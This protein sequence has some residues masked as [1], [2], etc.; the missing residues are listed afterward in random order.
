MGYQNAIVRFSVDKI[1]SGAVEGEEISILLPD[2]FGNINQLAVSEDAT[3]TA[4]ALDR[5]ILITNFVL[6]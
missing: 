5:S 1:G 2:P 6:Q 3:W 4:A